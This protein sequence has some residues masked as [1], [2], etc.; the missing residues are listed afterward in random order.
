MSLASGFYVRNHFRHLRDTDHGDCERYSKNFGREVPLSNHEYEHLDAVLVA[1]CTMLNGK[2]SVSFAVRF[3]PAKKTGRLKLTGHV[4]FVSGNRRTP[5]TIQPSLPQQY[6]RIATPEEC[7]LIRAKLSDGGDAQYPV[8]GFDETPAVFRSTEGE[9]V[10]IAKHRQLKAG[11]HV[12]VSRRSLLSAFHASLSAKELAT[13]PGLHA[14]LIQIPENPNLQVK[15]NIRSLLNFEITAKMAVYGFLKP[16][17]AY[18]LAPDCWEVLKDTEVAILIRI[19]RDF[20]PMYPRL[21]VQHRMTGHLA[22]DYLTRDD[23]VNEFVIQLKP[24]TRN[25]DILRIGLATGIA[26]SAWFLFEINFAEYAVEPQCVRIQFEFATGNA[27]TKLKWSAHELPKMLMDAVRGTTKLVSITGIPEAL[28]ITASDAGGQIVRIMQS[29][30]AEILLSFLRQARFPCVLS[31]S[32][33]GQLVLDRKR[34]AR[35]QPVGISGS[36]KITP[37]C[38]RERRL[39]DAYKRGHVSEYAIR[40]TVL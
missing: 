9:A 3:R 40:S 36:L 31:A 34:R 25:T 15:K 29:G 12:V 13:L 37:R 26:S 22:T 28:E 33:H 10:R 32:G 5:Y 39:L 14:A 2:D 27:T 8:E 23:K 6:F 35:E 21:I 17:D 18:E 7:Y 20:G 4:D 1:R 24:E 19:A 16:T 38:R 30:T 11:G